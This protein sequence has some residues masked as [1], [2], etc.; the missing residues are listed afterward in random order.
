MGAP[1]F[2][3]AE[4]VNKIYCIGKHLLYAIDNVCANIYNIP[5]YSYIIYGIFALRTQI[6]RSPV[7]LT[8]LY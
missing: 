2:A 7:H 8:R 5:M 3:F 4:R 1:F 6:R